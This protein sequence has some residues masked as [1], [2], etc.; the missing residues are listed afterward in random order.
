MVESY[1]G[2]KSGPET[3]AK[4][5]KMNAEAGLLDQAAQSMQGGGSGGGV[6]TGFSGGNPTIAY[7]QNLARVKAI[8]AQ[9]QNEATPYTAAEATT[10]TLPQQLKQDFADIY[11]D[12]DKRIKN[13]SGLGFFGGSR[14]GAAGEKGPVQAGLRFTAGAF[15]EP[16]RKLMS[17]LASIKLLAFGE[18][19]KN[20]TENER[21]LVTARMTP[22]GKSP[23]QW[24]ED[25][26]WVQRFAEAKAAAIT[27]P[28]GGSLLRGLAGEP[29]GNT[30]RKNVLGVGSGQP[31]SRFAV[32]VV[33]EE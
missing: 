1:S 33:E 4:V 27:R 11:D 17:R 20:L 14:L 19:G 23:A 18:G 5:S 29:G 25:L 13:K 8:E 16:N 7:P 2:M 6:V 32:E 26:Q 21:Q 3:Q 24:K 12:L 15:S 22:E 30:A 28:K 9:A 10:A 31:E